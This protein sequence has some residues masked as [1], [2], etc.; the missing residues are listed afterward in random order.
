MLFNQDILS[1]II[2]AA[3][4]IVYAILSVWTVGLAVGCLSGLFVT[5]RSEPKVDSGSVSVLV[6]AWNEADSIAPCIDSLKQSKYPEDKVEIVVVG[7]GTDQT[8]AIC[9][10]LAEGGQIK[11]IET[12]ERKGKWY[13][14][15]RGL[16]ACSGEV[17]AFTDGDCKVDREWLSQLT[18]RLSND[19]DGVIG[20]VLP[21]S[22]SN[23][24]AKG[25]QVLLP[26]IGVGAC[27]VSKT[28]TIP[29]FSG[30][31]SAFKNQV[32][33]ALKF[34]PSLI[35]DVVFTQKARRAFK[36]EFNPSANTYH[37]FA[38]DT[39]EFYKEVSR[40]IA[41]YFIEIRRSHSFG[42]TCV[43]ATLV[44]MP[45]ASV[46]FLVDLLRG[47]Y[48]VLALLGLVAIL[49]FSY[50]AISL[51]R[52][53]RLREIIHLPYAVLL[54]AVLGILSNVAVV[55]NLVHRKT[56][57]QLVEKARATEAGHDFKK[58]SRQREIPL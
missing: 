12:N 3:T 55:S 1:I 34:E 57:W 43:A 16:S 49:G 4:W 20:L 46:L 47:D 5:V 10:S 44:T 58:E 15:N 56:E 54:I 6:A 17:I 40:W 38:A 53:K 33:S 26:P 21:S 52:C 8:P 51:A 31:S 19:C 41:G 11:F 29:F 32:F 36:L 30:Y 39:A 35:E 9:R 42:L 14:L 18:G 13:D 25:F 48:G 23:Y 50:C 28:A 24:I 45:I 27:I 2:Q 37:D 7:G 22:D